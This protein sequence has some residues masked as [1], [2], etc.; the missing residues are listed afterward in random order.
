MIRDFH[1]IVKARLVDEINALED[2]VDSETWSSIDAVRKI[3]NIGAHM[4]KDIDLIVEVDPNEAQLLIG[5]IESLFK[6]WYVV[7]FEKQQ[8]AAAL[9]ALAEQK[10]E[11]KKGNGQSEESE[12]EK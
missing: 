6:D 5:L 2:K 12:A 10:T 9:K 3:G 7:R 8:R 11:D 1:K 4:E